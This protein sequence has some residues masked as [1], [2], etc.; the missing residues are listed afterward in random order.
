MLAILPKPFRYLLF[1]EKPNLNRLVSEV[2]ES[3]SL[4]VS[5]S[6]SIVVAQRALLMLGPKP[7]GGNW[8]P[9]EQLHGQL[10][11]IHPGFADLFESALESGEICLETPM[12][13]EHFS[14]AI[15]ERLRPL[16]EAADELNKADP[17]F[18]I[19]AASIVIQCIKA[20]APR[21]DLCSW[22]R[23]RGC[24]EGI[25]RSIQ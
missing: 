20:L 18:P 5:N 11:K 4:L 2:F 23:D 9:V 1:E 21:A 22:L 7:Q 16:Q 3:L 14:P 25:V 24:Q 8:A 10:L 12:R 17:E 19:Q 6:S 15:C 13:I